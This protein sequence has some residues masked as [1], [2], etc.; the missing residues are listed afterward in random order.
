M[1]HLLLGTDWTANRD[2]ILRRVSLDVRNEKENRILMVP[3]LVSHE[4]ERLLCAY[5]GDTASR[6]AEVLS[7]TRLARR[8]ADLYGSSAEESLD[9]GGRVVAMAAAVK[10]LSSVLKAYASAETKPEFLTSTSDTWV[11]HTLSSIISASCLR[12]RRRYSRCAIK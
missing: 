4:T 9:A 11:S 1:L 5:A 3:E 8:V 12:H 7:F 2:E 10:R 6:F